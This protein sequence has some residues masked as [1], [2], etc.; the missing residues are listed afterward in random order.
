MPIQSAS[1]NQKVD[2]LWKKI[3]YG[4]AKTDI[5]GNIDA[6]NEPNPSPL[7]I[8]GDKILQ[9]SDLIANIIPGSN[10]SVVTVYPT[11][12]PVE[13]TST[14]GIPTP[15]LTWQTGQTFWIPPEFG[16][17]YQIKVYISPS[18]QA[19]NVLTK[20]TQVFATGSGN[21]D[22]WVFD[23]QAGILN[24]NSNNTPYNAS[25]Q[26][27]SFTGNSVYISGAVYSGAFGLPST[28]NIGNL[29]LGNITF[30]GNTISSSEANGNI[31]IS[32]P[33][34]GIVQ[35]VGQDA[36]GIPAG[37]DSTRPSDPYV[38][39]LRFNTDRSDIE[40][41]NGTIWSTPAAGVIS[42][43]T[44]NPDGVANT[45]ALSSNS[46][47]LG[48]MVSINGTLQRPTSSYT[49]VNNNQIQFTEIP[50]TTDTIEV[51]RIVPG[52]QTVSAES[53][54][55]GTT[56][57]IL[58]TANVNIT[59]NLL[60][61]ANVTY[62]LGSET[63]QWKDLW[64]SGNSIYI[65]G[66]ELTVANGQLSIG[67]NTVGAADPYGNIN[68]AAYLGGSFSVG[69]I[70]A[71]T[72]NGGT[73]A[74]TYGGTGATTATGALTN[75]LPSGASTGYVLT[76]GGSGSYYWASAGGG[77]G[78]T[79]GQT[80]NTLRQSNT[81][82]QG[83]TVFALTGNITY[84]PGSGQLG[85]YINGVRQF[86][87]E[88]TETSSNV[89]TL[90]TGIDAGDVVFAEIN[91]S[92]SFDNYAN[93]TYASNIGNIAASG[94]TVQSAIESLENN[95]APLNNPVFT[96][97]TWNGGTIAVAYGGTGATTATGALTNLLPSGA[98]TGYVLTTGG[99]GSYYWAVSAGGGGGTVG[100]S[101]TTLRQ[102][103]AIVS[104]T[105]VIGL[106]G[107]SYTP[108]AGQLRVYVN[109]VRQFPAAY[110][111]T[112]N[113]SYTLSA[114]VVSGDAVFTE[115]DAF[116]S[117]NNYANLT[118]ASNVGNISAS[119]LTVQSA[120]ESLENNKAPLA[121]P[122]FSGVTTIGG[123]LVVQGNLFVNGNLTTI[124]ANNLSISDSMIYLADDNP[125]DTLDIGFVSA[126]TSA[127]RYQHTGFVR[128]AT[129]GT[130][131]LFA[132]VVPE[133]T[134]TID[135]TNANYSN[136]RLGNL[137]AIDGSFTGNIS[138]T[139]S[140][141]SIGYRDL[142]QVT[143]GNVTLALTDAGKHYYSTS[144]APQTITVPSNANV[145]FP[146]GTTIVVINRGLGNISVAKQVEVGMYL[147][148]NSTSA[149][150]T[151]TSY[152]MA[153]LV[154]TETNVWFI[155]GTG[156]A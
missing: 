3:V 81:A 64:V 51:R 89:F 139:V 27:I 59:G 127:V 40:Y 106:A 110:T 24:F 50:L 108:G 103:N 119:G 124:N 70:T 79:V 142:P 18:G 57:V 120:I 91:K 15:T 126:F 147:A 111:E 2:Y 42:S 100:Q 102:S 118:Y 16:S 31:M 44:I 140:G 74:V 62:S 53:L 22:L 94:L 58:D 86:P 5:S 49:I 130:W 92:Q 136:L 138:A 63:L 148:G 134:S 131:K 109:G 67:G 71:G 33:G 39:Y 87:T 34:T 32:A 9:Q 28:G 97:G 47:T 113:V 144:G 72:W 155:N 43:D 146:L 150:R 17:T 37:N 107:I 98:S 8:R 104:N 11:T 65:G 23:Y 41:W 149:T 66:S 129:D 101:L 154:K 156:L 145:A 25:N 7:L 105:T 12:L 95:K 99:S 151:L 116:S 38:G 61:S 77:G 13:C 112:S 26:P 35:F 55:L 10:S 117:F 115:I 80:I 93:L 60:P 122:V 56:A 84:T 52:T 68:V 121:S 114:N 88:Y 137:T 69:T 36:I 45:F 143:A 46:S 78:A 21:N 19:G 14:A 135:F 85:V 54:T 153:T 141:F 48:V 128:D 6:T 29:L 1:D 133:P 73:I 30:S 82:T 20:G 4:A 125:A 132:N 90:T 123:N 76:T 83:Q 75:L 96:S 152:G